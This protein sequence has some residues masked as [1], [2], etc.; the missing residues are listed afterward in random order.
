MLDVSK[1]FFVALNHLLQNETWAQDRL[2]PFAGAKV[3]IEAG[4]ITVDLLIDERGLFSSGDTLQQPDVTLTLPSDTV[5]KLLLDRQNL[6]SAVKLSG[7]ADIAESLAF[8]FR[9]L[10]WDIEAEMAGLIGDIPAR[11]LAMFGADF[12]AQF[13]ESAKRLTENVIEYATE[14]SQLLVSNCD[15]SG[16]SRAVNELQDNLVR[17]EKRIARL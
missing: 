1:P 11:R 12:V 8:V 2:R 7:S 6:F 16:F 5:V 13:Q 14:D 15:I 3:L 4:P 9:N 17:L 10:R